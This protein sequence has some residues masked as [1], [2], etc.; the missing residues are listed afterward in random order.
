VFWDII[1]FEG[2]KP[3]GVRD[4]LPD[5]FSDCYGRISRI[6]FKFLVFEDAVFCSKN[7]NKN[8][9]SPPLTS[10]ISSFQATLLFH[11]ICSYL[12]TCFSAFLIFGISSVSKINERIN[13]I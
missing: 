5:M 2:F 11:F 8:S 9:G 10:Y 12:A 3:D 6:P 1:G 7:S 13:K 4:I